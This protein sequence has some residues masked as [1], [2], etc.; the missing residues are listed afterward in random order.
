MTIDNRRGPSL[1]QEDPIVTPPKYRQKTLVL[2]SYW[3]RQRIGRS[4]RRRFGTVMVRVEFSDQIDQEFRL[5]RDDLV[6]GWNYRDC[7][8]CPTE[9]TLSGYITS[10]GKQNF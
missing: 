7:G 2:C 9:I 4:T 1:T 5:W 10:N 6:R 3:Y 8:D